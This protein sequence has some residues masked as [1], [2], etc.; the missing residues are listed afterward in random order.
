MN[1]S[2]SKAVKDSLE[3]SDHRIKLWRM[4]H[5]DKGERKHHK[6]H[7]EISRDWA[8]CEW[9]SGKRGFK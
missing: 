3:M 6:D 7:R 4:A 5:K 2:T 8:S 9:S 1:E